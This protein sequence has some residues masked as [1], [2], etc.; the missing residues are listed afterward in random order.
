MVT[1]GRPLLGQSVASRFWLLNSGIDSQYP[2]NVINCTAL[3]VEA[4]EGLL[5]INALSWASDYDP[6]ESCFSVYM[7]R[8]SSIDDFLNTSRDILCASG[9]SMSN[10]E[11]KEFRFSESVTVDLSEILEA[12]TKFGKHNLLGLVSTGG[13]VLRIKQRMGTIQIVFDS[14]VRSNFAF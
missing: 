11:W 5:L 1:D 9:V 13:Y 10:P 2:D 7:S 4:A 3:V 8:G 14:Q 12:P 6:S